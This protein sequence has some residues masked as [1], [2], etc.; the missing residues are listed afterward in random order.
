[1]VTGLVLLKLMP[2]KEKQTLARLKA[3][4]SVV[5]MSAVFGRWDLV[6]DMETDD[7]PMLSNIVVHEIRSIPGV[8]T[9]ETLVTTSI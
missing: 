4:S 2:G 6:I 5:H 9:T 1:M 8:L 7:L 3:L